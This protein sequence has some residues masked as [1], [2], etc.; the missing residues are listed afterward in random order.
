MTEAAPPANPYCFV[1][2]NP[3]A[4]VVVDEPDLA[5]LIDF[6]A[7]VAVYGLT[8]EEPATVIGDDLDR[9]VDVLGALALQVEFVFCGHGGALAGVRLQ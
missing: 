3:F 2:E 9:L 8:V 5:A 4:G 1:R 6:H 7:C